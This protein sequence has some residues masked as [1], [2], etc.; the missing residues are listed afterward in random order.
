MFHDGDLVMMPPGERSRTI[1]GMHGRVPMENGSPP[2]TYAVASVINGEPGGAAR[3]VGVTALRAIFIAPGIWLGG[4][5]VGM[6]VTGWPLLGMTMSASGAISI[7]LLGWYWL[8]T[9]FAPGSAAPS[10]EGARR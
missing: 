3:L 2:S 10:L 1:G 9:K 4:K 6:K 5:V 8:K 7:G